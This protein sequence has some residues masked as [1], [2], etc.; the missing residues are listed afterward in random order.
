MYEARQNKKSESHTISNLNRKSK[1]QI[2][3]NTDYINIKIRSNFPQIKT[4]NKNDSPIQRVILFKHSKEK[5]EYIIDYVNINRPERTAAGNHTTAFVVFIQEIYTALLG[6][7]YFEAL[8]NLKNLGIQLLN[9]PGYYRALST[10]RETYLKEIEDAKHE[11]IINWAGT[12]E[13]LSISYLYL[14]NSLM[15]TYHLPHMGDPKGHSEGNAINLM[16]TLLKKEI[17]NIEDKHLIVQCILNLFDTN[18]CEKL[19]GEVFLS[20]LATIRNLWIQH[21]KTIRSA[22]P[23]SKFKNM[24]TEIYLAASVKFAEKMGIRSDVLN[25]LI[26]VDC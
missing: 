15:Y 4:G 9:L 5:Q 19:E 3:N 20:W 16:H 24:S 13:N 8:D 12:L 10:K 14:R 21:L 26:L 25:V 11:E 22:F 17:I 2:L 6:N 7:T 1:K 23:K 18:N